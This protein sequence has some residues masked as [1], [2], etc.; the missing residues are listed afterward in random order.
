L[1]LDNI[2]LPADS[3]DF[4][5]TPRRDD[6]VGI[7]DNFIGPNSTTAGARRFR[8]SPLSLT[9]IPDMTILQEYVT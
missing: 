4:G 3:L 7:Y 8:A 5:R 6:G 9:S 1:G 2:I